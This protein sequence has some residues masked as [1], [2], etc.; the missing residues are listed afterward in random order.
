MNKVIV[1]D[2]TDWQYNEYLQNQPLETEKIRKGWAYQLVTSLMDDSFLLDTKA[3][4]ERRK[5]FRRLKKGI[6]R[7][8]KKYKRHAKYTQKILKDNA[9]NM[10][11]YCLV[12]FG[13]RMRKDRQGKGYIIESN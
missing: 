8:V 3:D 7:S 13:W 12:C 11:L 2:K 9:D 4:K 10:S 5:Q 6:V 1:T